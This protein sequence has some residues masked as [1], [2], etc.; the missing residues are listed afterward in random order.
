VLLYLFKEHINQLLLQT[1][2]T[3]RP[4]ALFYLD[5]DDFKIINDTMGHDIGD[6]FLQDFAAR[7]QN[8]LREID[9]FA[10]MGGDEFTILLPVV[11]CE[12][13]VDRIAQ[14][15]IRCVEQPWQVK[16]HSFR[17]T[18]SMG[19]T[20]YQGDQ[21]DAAG[22]MKQVD[23]ALYQVKDKGRNNYQFFSTRYE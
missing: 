11:D 23:I 20:V 17:S 8:C 22:L 2:R 14:R 21:L 7:I 13:H 5:I 19:I 18:V 12:E 4:F 16:G 9:M 3:G 6:A 1:K 15:I 10:R